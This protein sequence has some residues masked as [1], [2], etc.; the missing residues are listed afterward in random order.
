[1]PPKANT[2]WEVPLSL[3][4]RAR[5]ECPPLTRTRTRTSILRARVRAEKG[6]VRVSSLLLPIPL[7]CC[8]CI[9]RFPPPRHTHPHPRKHNNTRPCHSLARC[10]AQSGSSKRPCGSPEGSPSGG[11]Q[12]SSAEPGALHGDEGQRSS[13]FAHSRKFSVSHDLGDLTKRDSTS[14]YVLLCALLFHSVCEGL[15]VGAAQVSDPADPPLTIT[16]RPPAHTHPRPP[17]PPTPTPTHAHPPARARPRAERAPYACACVCVRV[18][19]CARAVLCVCVRDALHV[20]RLARQTVDCPRDAPAMRLTRSLLLLLLLILCW[21]GAA[22]AAAVAAAGVGAGA[23]GVAALRRLPILS[24]VSQLRCLLTRCSQ[25]LRWGPP[26]A[27]Q[28][29]PGGR[30]SA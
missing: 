16:A 25:R 27:R 5:L 19:A 8:R 18:R 6:G 14:A 11:R 30:Y 9:P 3:Y 12:S 20:C 23:G 15:A 24:S 28:T 17:T 2:W 7:I 22:G 29:L 21:R 13:S 1:L 26:F 10:T 4:I